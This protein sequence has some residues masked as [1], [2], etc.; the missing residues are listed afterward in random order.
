MSDE[1]IGRGEPVGQHS[2]SRGW[3]AELR[4]GLHWVLVSL[5]LL[6][7][8][9][10]LVAEAAPG[11]AEPA[12]F[13]A[14]AL[15]LF[16]V[17]AVVWLVDSEHHLSARWITVVALAAG[18][19]LCSQGLGWPSIVGVSCFAV[20]LAAMLIGIP[21]AAAVTLGQTALL[22]WTARAALYPDGAVV[23]AAVAADWLMLLLMIG[24]YH[25]IEQARE[26]EQRY[27]EY[28]RLVLD[29]AR[30]RKMGLE[31]ALEDLANANRQLAL[32]N[33]RMTTLRLVAEE[34]Q[35]TKMMFVAK[36]SHEFRT[37]LNMITG[38]VGLMADNPRIYTVAL[39]PEMREDLRIVH[40]NCQH[41]S[42]MIND[43]LSLSQIDAGRLIK[44]EIKHKR[45]KVFLM[46]FWKGLI[47]LS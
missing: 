32:A 7:A 23:A 42:N 16:G 8:A 47:W 17:V 11:R 43:V 46:S 15:G 33:E 4:P 2:G 26:W 29:Q 45:H 13:S 44:V 39:P 18:I 10:P 6:G 21:A 35:K 28:V 1:Q 25:P 12:A 30:N 27:V 34:A 38:L 37:P 24:I 9:V 19:P 36:V 14:V 3:E 40:R 20:A 5:A 22:V 31:Q 41:L